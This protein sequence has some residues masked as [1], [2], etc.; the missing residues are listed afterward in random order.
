MA[1]LATILCCLQVLFVY[2]ADAGSILSKNDLKDAILRRRIRQDHHHDDDEHSETAS[3]ERLLS[4]S[5]LYRYGLQ[6]DNAV[7]GQLPRLFEPIPSRL[8]YFL[9]IQWTLH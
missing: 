1:N 5:M 8:V 3:S 7:I 6:Q 9:S 4:V 2:Q